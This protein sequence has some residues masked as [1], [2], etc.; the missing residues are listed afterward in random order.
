MRGLGAFMTNRLKW[1]LLPLAAMALDLASKAWVLKS[2]KPGEQ[3]EIIEN[4]FYLKPSFNAGAIFG[5][6]QDTNPWIRTP[7]LL[8]AGLG[9]LGYFGWES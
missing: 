3:I 6:M 1:L 8:A 4:F 2:L 7:L 9:A 5:I